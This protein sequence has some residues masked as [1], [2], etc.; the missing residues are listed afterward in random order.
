MEELRQLVQGLVII[1]MLAVFLE[2]LLPSGGMQSYVKMVMGL[3]V[4]IAVLQ[5]LF[6]FTS[7]DFNL[8]VPEIVPVPAMSLEQVQADAERLSE[9]YHNQ[10]LEDY[11]QGIAKQ[12]LA[13]ARLNRQVTVLDAAVE[14]NTEEGEKYGH[15]QLIRLRVTDKEAD[16]GETKIEPVEITVG[17]QQEEISSKLSPEVEQA[18]E[19]LA[20]TVSNFYNLPQDKVQIIYVE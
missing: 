17:T 13:L 12:V 8:H 2:M 3:L 7:V 9:A 20:S 14:V 18:M 19:S 1:V 11:R 4:V 5:L 15:L 10:A 16:P 6:K